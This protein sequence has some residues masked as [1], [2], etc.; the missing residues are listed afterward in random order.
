MD[1][2]RAFAARS[3]A[4]ALCSAG[5]IV[6][7]MA[8]HFRLRHGCSTMPRKAVQLQLFRGGNMR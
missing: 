5:A 3:R 8:A 4:R 7:P 6:S 2:T 1:A